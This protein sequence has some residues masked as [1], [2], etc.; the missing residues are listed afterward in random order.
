MNLLYINPINNQ[1]EVLT[2]NYP[3]VDYMYYSFVKS[4]SND[5]DLIKILNTLLKEL[6]CTR[7]YDNGFRFLTVY[8]MYSMVLSDFYYYLVKL[9]NQFVYNQFIDRV[10][11]QHINNIVYE[12]NNPIVRDIKERP[13]PKDKRKTPPNK[14]F[15]SSEKDMFTGEVKY[16]YNNP[17]TGEEIISSDGNLLDELNAKKTKVKKT[18][19]KKTKVEKLDMSNITFNFNIK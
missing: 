11:A 17:K 15:K 2:L 16:I 6:D 5:D 13:N 9:N 18:S 1:Q 7:V 4:Y 3:N 19:P 10:V 8:P 12:H 14:F